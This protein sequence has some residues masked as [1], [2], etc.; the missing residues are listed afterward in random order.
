MPAASTAS[1]VAKPTSIALEKPQNGIR[2]LKHWRQD[3]LAGLVVSLI[4]LPFSLGIAVASG[5]DGQEGHAHPIVGITSAIIAGFVLPFLGGSYVTVSGPAAGLAP[6][7]LA[8]MMVLGRGNLGAGY[9]ILL[10]AIF[11]AGCLQL[12]LAKFKM[13]RFSAIFPT[14]VV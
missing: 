8:S 5:C 12:M 7:L 10:V 9:P 13:A 14:A 1:L 2:G 3:I 4:S 11:I 6:I